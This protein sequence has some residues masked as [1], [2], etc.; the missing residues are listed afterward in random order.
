MNIEF[1][2]PNIE[3]HIKGVYRIIFDDKYIY[4]GST[5]DLKHRFLGWK[6]N[7]LKNNLPNRIKNVIHECKKITFEVI[8]TGSDIKI[9]RAIE[10]YHMYF[11]KDL[12]AGNNSII[13]NKIPITTFDILPL[14]EKTHKMPQ[15]YYDLYG[16]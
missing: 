12:N 13:L 7:I 6:Y 14:I 4:F 8:E 9:L 15:E 5:K 1:N 3:Y 11:F 2:I 16:K 10:Y